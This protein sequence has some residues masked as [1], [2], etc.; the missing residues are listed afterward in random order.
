MKWISDV[1]GG[2]IQP[3]ASVFARREARKEAVQVIQ[4]KTVAAKQ[5]GETEVAL[6]AMEWE[7]IGQRLQA[8]TW[9]DEF[10]TVLVFS[11]FITSLMGA[12]LSVFGFPQ[13]SLAAAEMM[14][15]IAAMNIDYGT[16]LYITAMA[17]LGLRAIKP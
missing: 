6:T 7:L 13:L 8:G 9:K 5:Q 17:A 14:K 10:V 2:V 1:V 4:A 16:L 15:S 3:V 12:L 11:P